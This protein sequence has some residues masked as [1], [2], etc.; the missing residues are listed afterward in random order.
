MSETANLITEQALATLKTELDVLS[1]NLLTSQ[2]DVAAIQTYAENRLASIEALLTA[3]LA[4]TQAALIAQVVAAAQSIITHIPNPIAPAPPASVIPIGGVI[5]YSGP[6]DVFQI[7]GLGV[8][9]GKYTE[10]AIC[11]GALHSFSDGTS[12]Q[13][14]NFLNKF[15]IGGRPNIG[16]TTWVTDVD[17]DIVPTN[18]GG[19]ASY[20]LL[21]ENTPNHTHTLQMDGWYAR[22]TTNLDPPSVPYVFGVTRLDAPH[23]APPFQTLRTVITGTSQEAGTSPIAIPTTP[24]YYAAAYIVKVRE[25]Y[26]VR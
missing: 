22:G 20:A 6:S 17:G 4:A 13:T 9:S 1:Q 24:P 15:I 5:I 3:Q 8:E 26:S 14:Q 19:L 10:W 11:N 18:S 12:F 2:S 7:S 23:N 25:T 21:P 16:D